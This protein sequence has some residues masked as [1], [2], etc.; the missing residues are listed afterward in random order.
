M[1]LEAGLAVAEGQIDPTKDDGVPTSGGQAFV[2][3][4]D[5]SAAAPIIL[6]QEPAGRRRRRVAT[7]E[8]LLS[9]YIRDLRSTR[10][11]PKLQ[12]L[13]Q[14]RT[15]TDAVRAALIDAIARAKAPRSFAERNSDVLARRTPSDHPTPSSTAKRSSTRV[16]D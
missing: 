13:T 16:G 10:S 1:A 15:K 7:R 9:L 3:A 4:M 14:S 11:P 12:Q 8:Y 5:V 6:P 2:E